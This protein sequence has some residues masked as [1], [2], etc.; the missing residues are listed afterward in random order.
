MVAEWPADGSS[1]ELSERTGNITHS[2]MLRDFATT[3]SENI[4][5]R[6]AQGLSRRRHAEVNTFMGSRI[7]KAGCSHIAA[8]ERG[9]Y[10]DRKVGHS[11]QPHSKVCD[12]TLFCS[13]AGCWFRRGS[14]AIRKQQE[15]VVDMAMW[16]RPC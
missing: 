12:S 4:A 8:G 1:F 7:N 13:Y 6:K 16:W 15:A 9:F 5:R 14:A 10:R 11:F 3:N 2:P